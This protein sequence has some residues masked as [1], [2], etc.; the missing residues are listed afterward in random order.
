MRGNG[1]RDVYNGLA[2]QALYVEL[3][4]ADDTFNAVARYGYPCSS[5]QRRCGVHAC[6]DANV[7][8]SF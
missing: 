6:M 3:Y 4:V 2:E 5:V 1:E 7:F 8:M